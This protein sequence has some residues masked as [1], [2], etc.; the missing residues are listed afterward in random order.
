MMTPTQRTYTDVETGYNC[1]LH[2]SND[3]SKY[4]LIYEGQHD[5]IANGCEVNGFYISAFTPATIRLNTKKEIHLN[6]GQFY[7]LKEG[8]QVT[9]RKFMGFKKFTKI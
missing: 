9:H 3:L 1:R 5:I 4:H 8:E 2:T 7:H 6:S